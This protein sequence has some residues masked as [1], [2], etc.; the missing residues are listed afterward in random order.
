[1]KKIDG[2]DDALIGMASVG[3]KEGQGGVRVDTLVYNG[4]SIAATLIHR[5]GLESDEAMD[6]IEFNIAGAYVGDDAPII[7]F[8]MTWD[9]IELLADFEQDDPQ[10]P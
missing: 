5:D 3:Q 7:V 6:H 9:E 4:D 2:F 1:M 10:D 8:P